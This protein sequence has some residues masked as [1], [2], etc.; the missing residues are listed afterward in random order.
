MLMKVAISF[1]FFLIFQSLVLGMDFKIPPKIEKKSRKI[2]SHFPDEQPQ[3]SR[4]TGPYSAETLKK[5]N[6]QGNY[7]WFPG[8]TVVAGVSAE[9]LVFWERI[10]S[11]LKTVPGLLEHFSPLPTSSY[12]MTA[13]NLYTERWDMPSGNWA[14]FLSHNLPWFNGLHKE[15]E[16]LGFHPK[17]K[18]D[19]PLVSSIIYLPIHL[20]PTQNSKIH[21]L[22]NK[23]GIQNR[24]PEE[25]HIT[26][27]YQYKSMSDTYRRVLQHDVQ[28]TLKPLLASLAS[29]FELNEP[30]LC[31]FNDMTAFIPWAAESNPF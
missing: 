21:E 28:E 2:Q 9:S 24:I 10:Q 30:K 7:C 20:E 12:H 11:A 3:C 16:S 8:V 22:S 18:A 23:F 27:G 13:V 15:I 6:D 29:P 5:I 4:P 25:L 14:S 1:C 31:Y 17:V 26:L 19:L